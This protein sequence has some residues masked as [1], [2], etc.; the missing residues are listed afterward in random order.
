[1]G[2]GWEKR[3]GG[4]CAIVVIVGAVLATAAAVVCVILLCNDLWSK[5]RFHFVV[6]C[7]AD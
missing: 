1:M 5:N 7:G 3:G 2:I 6:V 4:L